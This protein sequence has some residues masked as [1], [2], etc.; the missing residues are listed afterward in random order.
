MATAA[1]QRAEE[2]RARARAEEQVARRARQLGIRR[3]D[4]PD[5]P[6]DAL[7]LLG[8]PAGRRRATPKR[9]QPAQRRRLA[10]RPRVQPTDPSDIGTTHDDDPPDKP[11]GQPARSPASPTTSG[12]KP[13]S[14][15]R[16]RRRALVGASGAAAA[17]ARR[18]AAPVRGVILTGTS[19][20]VGVLAL[21]ALYQLLTA[22][23]VAAAVLDLP[24]RALQWLSDPT[25][26]IPFAPGFPGDQ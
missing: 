14:R 15:R 18:A 23:D 1:Q 22:G 11:S 6:E 17:G 10:R 25:R 7:D 13:A 19:L 9:T 24:R 2:I 4:L 5:D 21:V 12:R 16:R 3:Q 20:L 26:S 8:P